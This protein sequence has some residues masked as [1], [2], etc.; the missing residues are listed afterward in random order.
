MAQDFPYK[1]LH[2]YLDTIFKGLSP[3]DNQIAQA[4]KDYWKT[5]NTHLKQSQRKKRI[6]ITITLDK[7][8]RDSLLLRCPANESISNYIKKWITQQTNQNSLN[9]QSK[10]IENT[11]IE[12]QLFIVCDYLEGLLYQRKHI[13]KDSIATLEQLLCKLQRLLEDKF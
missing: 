12:Q 3:S 1:S 6:E 11:Q 4:K 7:N 13:D 10:P 9:C 8:L 2:D 5:Y